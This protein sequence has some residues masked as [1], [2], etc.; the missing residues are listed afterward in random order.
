MF[1]KVKTDKEIENIR[2]SGRM[3]AAVLKLLERQVEPGMVTKDLDVMAAQE[4][5]V[6]GGRPA[7]LGYQGF[8]ATICV[9]LNDEIVHGIPGER[10]IQDGDLVSM[11]FGV[12]YQGMITDSAVT[13]I[14]GSND[15]ADVARLIGGTETALYAAIDVLKNGVRVG[16][17]ATAIEKVLKH[18]GLGIVR[19]L[20]GHGVGHHVH[21]EPNIP[22]Y[23]TANSGP[24]LKSGMTVAIEPMAMLG[25][26]SIGMYPD[27]WTV[28]TADQS[29]SAHFEHTLLITDAGAEILTDR[30]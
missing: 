9:S 24:I 13:V 21:E 6:L 30:A 17:I 1:T 22:N 23:G 12:S 15:E 27:G 20:V 2:E 29:L 25:R 11:D 5:K 8:P 26:E 18:H 28:V 4:L 19:E 16:D 3:L 10:E 14:A 7:F